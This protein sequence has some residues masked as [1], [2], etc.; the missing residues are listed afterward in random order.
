MDS[1]QVSGEQ[2]RVPT[3]STRPAAKGPSSNKEPAT[4]TYMNFCRSAH[5]QRENSPSRF[6]HIFAA[7]ETVKRRERLKYVTAKREKRCAMQFGEKNISLES[8]HGNDP[9]SW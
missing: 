2:Y 9:I 1:G 8:H 7:C 5:I 6:G 4:S 3:Y